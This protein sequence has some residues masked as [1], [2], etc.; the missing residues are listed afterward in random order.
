MPDHIA[1]DHKT[2]LEA[3]EGDRILLAEAVGFFIEDYP[4]IV[5]NIHQSLTADDGDGLK[6]NAHS[7]KGMLGNFGAHRA[8]RLAAQL[9][10]MGRTHSLEDGSRILL[11]LTREVEFVVQDL[12]RLI[13]DRRP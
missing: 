9:E 3:F 5:D 8:Y 2:L 6:R 4:P 7:L 1:V 13:Q 11:N 10:S 12:K